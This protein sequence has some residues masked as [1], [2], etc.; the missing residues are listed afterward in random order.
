MANQDNFRQRLDAV[1]RTLDVG[2][3]R[4]FLID[5]DQWDEDV[6]ADPEFAMWMMVAGSPALADLHG[7]ARE[8]LMSHGHEQEA[9]ALLSRSKKQ[10]PRAG[11]GGQRPA[12][13][14]EKREKRPGGHET[15]KQGSSRRG[16]PG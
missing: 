10:N 16:T 8:W 14:G 1:L 2:Q 7:R 12:A 15:K 6:P 4:K 9:E 3:V 13:K 11:K 5:E